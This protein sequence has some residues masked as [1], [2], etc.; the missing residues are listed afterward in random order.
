MPRAA[1]KRKSTATCPEREREADP[2]RASWSRQVL[3][4]AHAGLPGP[5]RS[6]NLRHRERSYRGTPRRVFDAAVRRA[7]ANSTDENL[8]SSLAGVIARR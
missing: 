1:V 2:G 5:A 3:N 4:V 8:D 6:G 7:T